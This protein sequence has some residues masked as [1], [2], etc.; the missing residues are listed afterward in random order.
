M[1]LVN[2]LPV[3][4]ASLTALAFAL[5]NLKAE[6]PVSQPAVAQSPI[7]ETEPTTSPRRLTV[8]VKVSE[9][10]DLKVQEGQEVK[11]GQVIAA[12]DREKQRLESQ[13]QQL[14][15]SRPNL[16][17]YTPLAPTPPQ[18]VPA[19]KALPPTSYLE[20]EAEGERAKAAISSVE[21]E[22]ETKK[23][24]I[25]Y[26]KELP[27]LDPIILEHE[28]V[29]FKELKQK[30]TAAVRDYQLAVGKLQTA[31]NQ[32]AY[33]EY[34]ASLE[35]ARRVEEVNQ[36]RSNYERQLAEYQQRLGEREFQVAQVKAKLNEVENAISSLSV[37]KSPYDGTV[38]RVKWLGQSPDGS[39]TAEITLMIAREKR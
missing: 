19:A 14:T 22:I 35:A 24:E 39:L 32:R 11:K 30:H 36:A 34:Q 20:H 26:L 16:Q 25:A 3:G 7:A 13:K 31:K 23:Q 15:L 27:N 1:N 9:P 10:Q 5:S 21:S 8:T 18:P 29:K 38:R 37:V 4:L 2:L 12:R 17:S 28:Q 33:Q 6:S